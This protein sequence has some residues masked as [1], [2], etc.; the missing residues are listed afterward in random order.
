MIKAAEIFSSVT[1]WLY[2]LNSS[3]TIWLSFLLLIISAV[4]PSKTINKLHFLLELHSSIFLLTCSILFEYS[5]KVI[6]FSKLSRPLFSCLLMRY[7]YF[8]SM[9]SLVYINFISYSIIII[10]FLFYQIEWCI[11]PDPEPPIINIL[12]GSSGICGK[13]GLWP[14]VSFSN[15]VVIIFCS[16]LLYY[17]I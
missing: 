5:L 13:I 15:I 2:Y 11:F 12:Y 17:S 3:V 4:I 10:I 8:A 9:W 16:I 1:I 7:W 6:R 14:F